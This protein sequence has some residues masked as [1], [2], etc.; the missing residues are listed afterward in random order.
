M[1]IQNLNFNINKAPVMRGFIRPKH[2]YNDSFVKQA[3][4]NN[5]EPNDNSYNSFIKW[6][7]K[8]NFTD[9]ILNIIYNN[10][11]K[12]GSG[13]EGSVYEIPGNKQWVLKVYDNCQYTKR[14]SDNAQITQIQDSVPNL[15][16]GQSI[17][18]IIVPE[19]CEY[20][21]IIYVL[22]KQKGKTYG[23]PHT[24]YRRISEETIKK[25][26]AF[27]SEL[28]DYPIESFKRLIQEVSYSNSRGYRF[29]CLN[30]NNI[31]LDR[32]E[33]KINLVDV[34]CYN[35]E[36]ETKQFGDILYGILDGSNILNIEKSRADETLKQEVQK[37]I[38]IIINKFL[39]A[40]RECGEKFE[41][42]NLLR[43]LFLTNCFDNFIDKD[44]NRRKIDLLNKLI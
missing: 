32:N 28:S 6:A 19:N 2:S 43:V 40:M 14:L 29:D 7:K 25:Y 36:P 33:R 39:T 3:F 16:I 27:L 17:A 9:E 44:S 37:Y 1:K 30:P 26:I 5:Y 42:T 35:S 41:E 11:N 10:D 24:N 20:S 12:I 21:K 34:K 38:D 13:F 18:K 22:K 31:M 15:N 23:I 4:F 8:T